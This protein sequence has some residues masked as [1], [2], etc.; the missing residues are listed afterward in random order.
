MN[1]EDRKFLK[2]REEAVLSYNADKMRAYLKKYNGEEV[3]NSR[4]KMMN[5]T[6]LI[7][8]GCYAIL[9]MTSCTGAQ[10]QKACRWLLS[11]GFRHDGFGRPLVE[12]MFN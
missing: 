2:D 12:R 8:S 3:Y 10:K 6:M 1:K 7:A 4:L 11:H 9:E 5:D